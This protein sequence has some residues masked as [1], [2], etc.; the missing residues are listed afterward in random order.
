MKAKLISAIVSLGLLGGL[1]PNGAIAADSL[2]LGTIS[3][4]TGGG[5]ENA[6]VST[7]GLITEI[8]AA[9]AGG[10]VTAAPGAGY[11]VTNKSSGSVLITFNEPVGAAAA[12]NVIRNAITCK[13]SGGTD[14]QAT[15]SLTVFESNLPADAAVKSMVINNSTHYYAYIDKSASWSQAYNAAKG[16]TYKGLQGYLATVGSAEEHSLLRSMSSKTAWIGGSRYTG[17]AD[18]DTAP[19]GSAQGNVD[20][21]WSCGPEAKTSFFTYINETGMAA[22]PGVW[23]GFAAG[24]PD[25]K[26][27]A[28]K[29][30]AYNE[31]VQEPCVAMNTDPLGSW[32]DLADSASAASGYFVE[33]STYGTESEKTQ[34]ISA[35]VTISGIKAEQTPQIKANSDG[36]LYGFDAG[37]SYTVNGLQVSPLSD[38]TMQI[39]QEWYGTTVSIVKKGNGTTTADSAP[40]RLVI[41]SDI[42][43]FDLSG[44]AYDIAGSKLKNTSANLE[45]S[46]DGADWKPCSSPETAGVTA[47]NGSKITVRQKDLISNVKTL[48]IALT[49]KPDM[50]KDIAVDY[51]NER[52]DKYNSATME[53]SV[54]GA[55]FASGKLEESISDIVPAYG[56]SSLT[57]NVRYAK[58][59]ETAE[60]DAASV[61]IPARM[62]APEVA[63]TDETGADS[64]DGSITV[65]GGLCEYKKDGGEYTDIT[66]T[67][68][69]GLEPGTYYVRTKA[70]AAAFASVPVAVTVEEGFDPD[71]VF[72]EG[73]AE[74]IESSVPGVAQAIKILKDIT[75]SAEITLTRSLFIDLNGH[76]LT[77]GV[78]KPVI[79]VDG[80]DLNIVI[81]DSAGGSVIRGFNGAD[82]EIG[83]A[84]GDAVDVRASVNCT[85]LVEKNVSIYGGDGGDASSETGGNGGAGIVGAGL[86]LEIEG[87]VYGGAGGDAKTTLAGR[88]GAAVDLT[89]GKVTNYGTVIGGKGGNINGGIAGAGGNAVI[90]VTGDIVNTGTARGGNGGTGYGTPGDG[91]DCFVSSGTI[92]GTGTF[93]NGNDGQRMIPG[94]G[95][96]GSGDDSVLLPTCNV[97]ASYA[98]KQYELKLTGR[99]TN[100]VIYYTLD[101]KRPTTRSNVYEKPIVLKESV[102]LKFFEVGSRTSDV[103]TKSI[104]IVD[105]VAKLSSDAGKT[106]Y[107]SPVSSSRFYPDEAI[108]RYDVLTSLYKLLDFQRSSKYLTSEFSDVDEDMREI[109]AYFQS[110]NIIDGYN[111]YSFKGERGLTRAEFVKIMAIILNL[112]TTNYKASYNDVKGH[113]A[114]DYIARFT[115]LGYLKGYDDG[116]FKPDREMTRAEFV[117]I[118]N[119]ITGVKITNTAS[120]FKDVDNGH[121]AKN[122]IMSSYIK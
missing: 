30:Y 3:G 86:M 26:S 31:A 87:T 94:G 92:T 9:A 113:W 96:G 105:N 39:K 16:C 104:K 49:V 65:S 47:Q 52:L 57:V 75:T 35:N 44:V 25:N 71:A 120:V 28:G 36:K 38:G 41:Q 95:D 108:T 118:V 78:N 73:N 8:E 115:Q 99:Q 60:S 74:L 81:T 46:V 34:R 56:S 5:F 72:G 42:V 24:K 107:I 59:A 68:A 45:Y 20:F 17:A 27:A 37:G 55:A 91:G 93:K 54:N 101:G 29:S 111:D 48:T 97:T 18:G 62:A 112:N 53:Y 15:V 69:A 14:L 1:V 103:V 79:L 83:E 82:G 90:C 84:G 32:D 7:A 121:W 114:E 102:T 50:P 110:A 122:E 85:L 116:E 6:V 117:A 11:T 19:S 2:N 106:R 98:I 109:V 63:K 119:R 77:A 67:T 100:S 51:T 61:V 13:N 40:Q 23:N 66:G 89:G 33:F 43:L 70:T 10:E 22:K 21:Y 88:G 58:T 80:T 64:K 12:Q 4:V 76:K